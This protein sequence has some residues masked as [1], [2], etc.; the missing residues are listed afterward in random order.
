MAVSDDHRRQAVRR[1]IRAGYGA[2]RQRDKCRSRRGRHRGFIGGRCC[3]TRPTPGSIRRK[4]K[5]GYEISFNRY[6]YK[7]QPLRSLEAIRAD[8]LALETRNRGPDGRYHRGEPMIDGL[9]P[10]PEIKPSGLPWLGSVPA[11]WEV[12][13]NGR[14]FGARRERIPDL[15]ILEVSIR[16]GVRIRDMGT[17]GASRR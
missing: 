14:L 5:I 10:Y 8:I 17:A 13:R 11:H 3:R 4:T 6:F 2:A 7:P 1:R 15:P 12:R 9:R 16:T